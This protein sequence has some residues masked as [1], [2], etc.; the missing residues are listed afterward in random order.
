MIRKSLS[1]DDAPDGSKICFFAKTVKS[2][3]QESGFCADMATFGGV[4]RAR[5]ARSLFR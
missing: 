2:R 4:L 1:W 5:T 3:V